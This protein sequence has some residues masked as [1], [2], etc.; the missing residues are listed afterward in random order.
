MVPS[1]PDA[2]PELLL[3]RSMNYNRLVFSPMSVVA[4]DDVHLFESMQ[5]GLRGEGNEWVSLHRNFVASLLE[6]PLI[7][8]IQ[9]QKLCTFN[10]ESL[11]RFKTPCT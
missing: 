10:A 3:E 11:H 5:K 7:A 2:E 4:H 1:L 6:L 8:N 9:R